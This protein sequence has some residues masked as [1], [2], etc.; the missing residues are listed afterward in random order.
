MD[1]CTTIGR[2]LDKW[3]ERYEVS[4]FHD[5]LD[6]TNYEVIVNLEDITYQINLQLPNV[7]A[8]QDKSPSTLD[9]HIW[10]SVKNQGLVIEKTNGD[11]L[12]KC[13]M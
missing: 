8:L 1:W 12:E 4:L 5:L 2:Q 3:D 11:Y 10:E 6:E 7:A 13:Y 9:R